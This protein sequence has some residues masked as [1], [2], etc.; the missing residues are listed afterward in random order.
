MFTQPLL[1]ES[2]HNALIV[3]PTLNIFS[4]MKQALSVRLIPNL[5]W[6]AE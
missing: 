3:Y 6:T 1:Y 5:I 4:F 2:Y